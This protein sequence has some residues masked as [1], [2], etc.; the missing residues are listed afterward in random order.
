MVLSYL[1][2]NIIIHETDF[3]RF[4]DGPTL[5]TEENNEKAFLLLCATTANCN[6]CLC[7]H[8]GLNTDNEHSITHI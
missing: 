3:I 4:T 6:T 5:L 2:Y 1:V 8:I 7:T